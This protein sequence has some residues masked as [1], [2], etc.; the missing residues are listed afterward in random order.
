LPTFPHVSTLI[1]TLVSGFATVNGFYLADQ[2]LIGGLQNF[3]QFLSSHRNAHEIIE[4]NQETL[5][6]GA[7]ERA[8]GSE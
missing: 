8:T 3:M 6:C 7:R 5:A 2:G 4:N 1:A